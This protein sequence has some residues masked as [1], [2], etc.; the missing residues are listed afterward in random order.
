MILFFLI[1]IALIV[2]GIY[3]IIKNKRMLKGKRVHAVVQGC[4]PSYNN[5]ASG[6]IPCM[7][8]TLEIPTSYGIIYK[9]MKDFDTYNQGDTIEI[10]YDEK[11]DRMELAENV[12][13][14]RGAGP[15]ACIGFGVLI[16]IIIGLV[17]AMEYSEPVRQNAPRML[18]YALSLAFVV[19]GFWSG[20]L[21]PYRKN[22]E[23]VHCHTV[24]G[25]IVDYERKRSGRRQDITYCPTYE[26]YKNGKLVR[27]ESTVSGNSKKYCQIGRKVTIVINDVTGETHC[28]EDLQTSMKMGIFFF[29]AGI[30]LQVLFLT[31]K[32]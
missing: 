29:I 22:R 12:Q 25:Q 1:G 18:G 9:T 30:V 6:E 23:M 8:I 5:L 3:V 16:C 14:N 28:K 24:E 27:M 10:Y 21:R 26:F 2:L 15:Y 11:R 13:Q 20:I 19:V 31:D 32:M 7:E 17:E 4:V